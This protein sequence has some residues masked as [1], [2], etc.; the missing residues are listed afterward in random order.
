MANFS[1]SA[2]CDHSALAKLGACGRRYFDLEALFG[3]V[4]RFDARR[5]RGRTGAVTSTPRHLDAEL[6]DHGRAFEAAWAHELATLIE[7]KRL[8][9]AE[10]EAVARSAREATAAVAAKIEMACAITLDGL[11]VKARAILWRRNGEPLGTIGPADRTR[12]AAKLAPPTP[13][14]H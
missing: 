7:M 8:R 2:E 12:D 4:E 6:L 9:T 3:R 1:V 11:K 14:A 5:N 10:A 13:Q